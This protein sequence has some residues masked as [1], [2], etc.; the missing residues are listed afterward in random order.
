MSDDHYDILH[1]H[2]LQRNLEDVWHGRYYCD[3]EDR[4][5]WTVFHD[6]VV[7]AGGDDDGEN[8]EDRCVDGVLLVRA[9][10]GIDRPMRQQD[11]L[12]HREVVWSWDVPE[13]VPVN[14]SR[15][16]HSNH[17]GT[18]EIESIHLV[19]DALVRETG[20]VEVVM[21]VNDDY[22]VS[23]HYRCWDIG[24]TKDDHCRSG[25]NWISN[26]IAGIHSNFLF[27]RLMG[28]NGLSPLVVA[29]RPYEE[30]HCWRRWTMKLDV[31]VPSRYPSEAES[32]SPCSLCK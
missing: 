31:W 7:V 16:V 1:L 2:R 23:V 14:L 11:M 29:A 22:G 15:I 20:T 28:K 6:G 10:D 30:N 5:V 32:S 25:L 26:V 12:H 24:W 4:E 9:R 19:I 3:D 17:D 21:N 27:Q 18:A 8:D 13:M